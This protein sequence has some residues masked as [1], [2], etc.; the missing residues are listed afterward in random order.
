M[1]LVM[2]GTSASIHKLVKVGSFL[3]VSCNVPGWN[4][5]P[6]C[7]IWYSLYYNDAKG[8]PCVQF[9]SI[10]TDISIQQRSFA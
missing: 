10:K 7:L 4:R 8:E 1:I 2:D 9:Q 3:K 6:L 5:E